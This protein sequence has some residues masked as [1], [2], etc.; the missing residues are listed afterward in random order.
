MVTP[1]IVI[2]SSS[3]SSTSSNSSSNFSCPGC[4]YSSVKILNIDE[5]SLTFFTLLIV[6]YL[7]NDPN[8]LSLLHLL[9]HVL[10]L[11]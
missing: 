2:K 3:S 4:A 10:Y 1:K 11:G 6:E 8:S 7:T 5:I 9:Q